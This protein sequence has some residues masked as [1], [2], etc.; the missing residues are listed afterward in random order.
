MQLPKTMNT[1]RPFTTQVYRLICWI[2]YIVGDP[3][4]LKLLSRDVCHTMWAMAKPR[5]PRTEWSWWL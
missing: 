4:D 2:A 1:A 3:E 5:P